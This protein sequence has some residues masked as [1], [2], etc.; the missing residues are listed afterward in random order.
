MTQPD[1]KREQVIAQ[2][3]EAF[4]GVKLGQGVGLHETVVVDD[5]GDAAARKAARLKDEAHD[6]HKLV[7]DPALEKIRGVGGLAC[8]DAESLRFHLPAYLVLV[9]RFTQADADVV[10]SVMFQL[11]ELSAYDRARLGLLSPEQRRAVR[12]FLTFMRDTAGSESSWEP[13]LSIALEGY[14][15]QE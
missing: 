5:Y 7:T 13:Q 11:T 2:I 1:K 15:S 12:A 10:Q 9:T 14:W 4:R 3:E 8:M 6:W